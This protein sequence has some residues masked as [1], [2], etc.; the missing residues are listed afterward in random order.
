MIS[1]LRLPA[2]KIAFGVALV[3]VAGAGLWWWGQQEGLRA[4]RTSPV[5]ATLTGEAYARAEFKAPARVPKAWGKPA[6]QSQG[7]G[8]VYEIF[9]PPVIYFHAS[10][11]A[12]SVTPPSV[13]QDGALAFGL[14]LLDVRRE[15]YRLQLMGYLGST[16]DYLGTFVSPQISETLLA[17]PGRRFEE[18][19]LTLKDFAVRK[20]NVAAPGELP[21]YDIAAFAVVHDERT[22]EEVTLDNRERRFTDTPLAILRLGAQAKPREVREGD[23][24]AENDATY[25]IERIQLYPPEVVV[26]KQVPGLPFPELRVLKPAGAVAKKSDSP[27]K[28]FQRA[29]RRGIVERPA[30]R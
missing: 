30:H 9:T 1:S 5:A 27:D 16:Q 24:F 18:L 10:A 11:R 4:L 28:R 22:G 23:E 6:V 13:F 20:V 15:L 21:V 3:A 26:A 8:W 7:G 29:D 2:E 14:E 12:F 25:R 19:G 17:R